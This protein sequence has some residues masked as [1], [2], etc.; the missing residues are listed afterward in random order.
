VRKFPQPHTADR[1]LE[2]LKAV[3]HEWGIEGS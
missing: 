2:A 3:L 1:V